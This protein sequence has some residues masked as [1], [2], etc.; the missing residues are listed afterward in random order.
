MRERKRL[1]SG[2]SGSSFP[3]DFSPP[4]ITTVC[5][6]GCLNK[7]LGC[8]FEAKIWPFL[9]ALALVSYPACLQYKCMPKPKKWACQKLFLFPKSVSNITDSAIDSQKRSTCLLYT[10]HHARIA[11]S[12]VRQLVQGSMLSILL[13]DPASF[14]YYR[15]M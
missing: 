7:K 5:S 9:T 2:I 6:A 1:K 15:Y 8:A 11:Y 12:L 4:A 3:I 13:C 10:V 14:A